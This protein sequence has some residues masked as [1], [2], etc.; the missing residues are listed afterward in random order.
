MDLSVVKKYIFLLMRPGAWPPRGISAGTA[1][2]PIP[3]LKEKE[4]KKV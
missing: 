3:T 4:K 2:A 1:P